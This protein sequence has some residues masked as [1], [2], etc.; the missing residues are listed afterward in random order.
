M[1]PSNENLEKLIHV[2]NNKDLSEFRR[3]RGKAKNMK[4]KS[5]NN[6]ASVQKINTILSSIK[7]PGLLA[8]IENDK[9][10]SGPVNPKIRN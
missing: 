4:R 9:I 8:N 7:L 3:D 1:E 5:A 6:A 2:K 10:R